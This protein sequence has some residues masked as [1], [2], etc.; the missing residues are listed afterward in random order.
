MQLKTIIWDW[1]GTLLNDLDICISCIN[2]LLK[3]RDL[4]LL[5]IDQYKEV[6]AFPIRDYYSSIGFDF[7]YEDFEVPA[8]E[9][10][11]LYEQGVTEC[12]LHPASTEVLTHFRNKGM[13]QFVLS[14]MH[15]TMLQETLLHNNIIHYFESFSGLNNHYAVSKVARGLELF[16]IFPIDKNTACMIGDTIHD[17]QVAQALEIKCVLIADGHQSK[18][19][20]ESTGATVFNNLAELIY[21]TDISL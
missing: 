10:I 3:A 5:D 20:L 12:Q 16:K 19:R 1:N 9:F 14:A 17:Y 15:Q 8:R 11:E 7:T 2:A 13:R 18:Q 4:P 21:N 6:F